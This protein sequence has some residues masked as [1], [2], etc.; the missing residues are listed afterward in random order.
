M[1]K[2]IN[3]HECI[4]VFILFIFFLSIFL[5]IFFITEKSYEE[6]KKNKSQVKY[7]FE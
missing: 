4:L 2:K 7:L 1:K 5:R 6:Y 3:K